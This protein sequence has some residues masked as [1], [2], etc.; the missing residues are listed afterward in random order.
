MFCFAHLKTFIR[1]VFTNFDILVEFIGL[2]SIQ[3]TTIGK[4]ILKEK[5]QCPNIMFFIAPFIQFL[6]S[7]TSIKLE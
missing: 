3:S 7:I 2:V 1:G 6:A 5:M 4:E